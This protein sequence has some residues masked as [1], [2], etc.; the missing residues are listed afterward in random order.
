MLMPMPRERGGGIE[1]FPRR[2]AVG[3][4]RFVLIPPQEDSA[5]GLLDPHLAE[6][7]GLPDEG[8]LSPANL[9][10]APMGEELPIPAEKPAPPFR[11]SDT[12]RQRMIDRLIHREGG[13]VNDPRDRGGP[14][15]YG[16]TQIAI[17]DYNRLM[18]MESGT[19]L[20]KPPPALSRVEAEAVLDKILSAYK[21]DRIHDDLL[22]EQIF[23]MA[24]NHGP[25]QAVGLLQEVLNIN[26]Y[27]VSVDGILGPETRNTLNKLSLDADLKRRVNNDLVKRREDFYRTLI[28][29]DPTQKGFERSWYRRARSFLLLPPPPY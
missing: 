21:F 4:W 7:P 26:G 10:Q 11:L 3:P 17:D 22:R 23:D 12:E 27:L 13:Y 28:Q 16:V 5:Y 6:E 29:Q 19:L 1:E 2:N 18:G 25:G 15:N 8:L 9:R 20:Q 24:V 14:T